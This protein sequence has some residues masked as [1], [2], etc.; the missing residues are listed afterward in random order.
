MAKISFETRKVEQREIA[1]PAFASGVEEQ[2]HDGN[3]HV[4]GGGT[5]ILS[6]GSSLKVSIDGNRPYADFG[7]EDFDDVKVTLTFN[8][9]PIHQDPFWF[10]SSP[11]ARD[12]FA[13]ILAELDRLTARVRAEMEKV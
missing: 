8:K 3:P 6:D 13:E 7:G 11:D 4:I 2:D 12:G 10:G 1:L 5:A 9:H